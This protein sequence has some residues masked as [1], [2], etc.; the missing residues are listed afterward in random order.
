MFRVKNKNIYMTENDFGVVLPIKFISGDVLETDTIKFIIYKE[1]NEDEKEIIITKDFSVVDN[2]LEFELTK[3]ESVLLEKDVY[4]YGIKQ[5]RDN[6][7]V[8]TVIVDRQ[9][10]VERGIKEV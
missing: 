5:Y 6:D 7:L 2:I 10:I 9:F 1:K 4:K 3:E 8:D